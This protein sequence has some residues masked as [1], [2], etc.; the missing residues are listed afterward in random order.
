M[1]VMPGGGR[2]PGLGFGRGAA[3]SAG[4]IPPAGATAGGLHPFDPGG[5]KPGLGLGRGLKGAGIAAAAAVDLQIAAGDIRITPASPVAN[6]PMTVTM[7]VRNAGSQP[8]AE[9]RVLAVLTAGGVEVARKE[10][11]SAVG[12][13]AAVSLTWEVNAPPGSPATVAV[14][15]TAANDGNPANNQ[16]R[17]IVVGRPRTLTPRSTIGT[18]R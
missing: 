3:G 10:F 5:A 2:G 8:V 1:F 6:A 7:T 18:T 12:A 4:T 9:A 16:A 14:T 11:S 13:A 15:V 17:A